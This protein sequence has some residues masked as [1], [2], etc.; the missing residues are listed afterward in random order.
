MTCHKNALV[1]LNLDT[2]TNRH[3]TIS[4]KFAKDGI[5]Y[6]TLTDLLVKRSETNHREVKKHEAYNV[7][8]ANTDRMKDSTVIYLQNLLNEDTNKKTK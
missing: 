3:E 6:K 5:K 7:A 1:K 8:F 2:L 4:L